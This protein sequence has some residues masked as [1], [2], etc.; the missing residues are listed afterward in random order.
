MYSLSLGAVAAVTNIANPI[1]LARKVMDKTDHCLLV[2]EGAN[3]FAE[4]CDI[5]FVDPTT[6]VTAACLEE[7]ETF[8]K[9]QTAVDS[10]F[11]NK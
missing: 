6:L 10:L 9:Y 5:K 8:K 7:W 2:G 1:S 3:Q 4:E 11:N